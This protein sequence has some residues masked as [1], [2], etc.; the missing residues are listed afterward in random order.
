MNPLNGT[1]NCATTANGVNKHR[2][3]RNV[4]LV[5]A[6]VNAVLSLA[7]IV[8]GLAFH[9]AAMF[10]D[11]VHSLSD[12][13][14]D[15]L[16]LWLNR[17]AGHGPDQEHPYGHAR[18]E[19]LGTL[20][21]GGLLLLVSLG[22]AMDIAQNVWTQQQPALILGWPLLSLA[23]VMILAKEGLYHYSRHYAEK[24]NSQLLLAN[25]WHS[26]SDVFSSLVVLLGLLGALLGWP[27]IEPLAALVVVA[28]IA[29]MALQL[30]YQSIQEFLDRGLPKAD[31]EAMR[32]EILTVPGVKDAHD[33]RTRKAGGQQIFLDVHLCV[34][35]HLSVSEGHHIGDQ[36][37]QQLHRVFDDLHDVVIHIDVAND[38][39]HGMT[40]A[41]CRADVVAH[42]QQGLQLANA[43]QATLHYLPDGLEA[44]MV[45]DAQDDG[46]DL[47][48]RCQQLLADTPWLVEIRL[49]RSVLVQR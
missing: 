27:W 12:L 30:M 36:V 5:N 1:N 48:A 14:T 45:I 13:L 37:V 34:D 29:K 31:L 24:V 22:L 3:I 25:A 33:L 11:G 23:V 44:W 15:G 40:L 7:K 6:L 19:T 35:A 18:F 21:M 41:P 9:S 47:K 32:T 28:L 20:V 16:V 49:L 4:T 8:A 26:R 17:I 46:P 10:A 38:Q 42:L 43:K 2:V 39:E